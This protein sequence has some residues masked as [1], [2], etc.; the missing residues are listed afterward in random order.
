[1]PAGPERCIEVASTGAHVECVDCGAE[2]DGDVRLR[3]NKGRAPW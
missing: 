2:Q 3:F 1:V